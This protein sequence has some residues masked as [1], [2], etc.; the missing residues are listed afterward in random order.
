M[1]AVSE[2]FRTPVPREMP[3][4][5]NIPGYNELIVH[6][7][8]SSNTNRTLEVL[9]ATGAT[10]AKGS[11]VYLSGSNGTLAQ[12]TKARADANAT[13]PGFGVLGADIINNAT[14]ECQFSG[15]LEGIDTSAF[16]AGDRLYVSGATAG[17]LT[18]TLPVH[19][20][21]SQLVAVA[22]TISATAGIIFIFPCFDLHG[23]ETG[24]MSNSFK[25]GDGAA[26]AKV[27]QFTNAFA[28]QLT[29]T[30]TAARTLTL[31][32]AT[33]TLVGKNTTDTMANKTLTTPVIG[34]ATGTSLAL[35]GG[36]G[37]NGKAIQ[38]PY[39]IGAALTAYSAGANGLA[40]AADMSALV[41][42]V[43]AIHTA[44]INIG[45]TST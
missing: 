14:G 18:R 2:Q 41:A 30:P 32:D 33:D 6:V 38:T 23:S 34:T 3:S 5:P 7:A 37:I 16:T 13:M 25:I 42:K 4:L 21:M 17:L 9:N 31:P 24:T 15:L 20:N 11:V 27:L 45:I 28:G 36:L 35:T 40:N 19:P 44:L 43:Q 12:V 8:D 1:V 26:G 22:L 29:W 39:A 10:I